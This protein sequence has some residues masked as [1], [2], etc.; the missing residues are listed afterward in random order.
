MLIGDGSFN[1]LV[2]FLMVQERRLLWGRKRGFQLLRV[3]VRL[4][5][6]ASLDVIIPV[7]WE[8]FS[9]NPE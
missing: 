1:A 9:R 8:D 6:M 2:T 7:A 4:A 3:Y 5:P